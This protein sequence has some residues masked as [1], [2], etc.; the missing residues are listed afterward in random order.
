MVDWQHPYSTYIVGGYPLSVYLICD[1]AG[2]KHLLGFSVD[3]WSYL[4]S[5]YSEAAF[6]IREREKE[7]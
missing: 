4:V 6:A 7:K 2:G 5:S 3:S 1:L